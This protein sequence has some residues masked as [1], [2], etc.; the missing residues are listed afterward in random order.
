M[1]IMITRVAYCDNCA[2]THHPVRSD[3]FVVKGRTKKQLTI[4][5]AEEAHTFGFTPHLFQLEKTEKGYAYFAMTCAMC[6]CGVDIDIQDD[7]PLVTIREVIHS[8]MKVSD[9]N[10]L[11]QFRDSGYRL[12]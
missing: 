4:L 10:A 1:G 9:W 5:Y 7:K 12:D 3:I 2:K 6:G 11:V 8:K